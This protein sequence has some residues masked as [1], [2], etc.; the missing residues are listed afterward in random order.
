MR[1]LIDTN[2][3]LDLLVRRQ[4]WEREA[5]LIRGMAYFGDAELWVPAKSFT[6]LFYIM[7][8][9]FPS[10]CVQQLF[11]ECRKDFHLCSL[12]EEDV[13]EACHRSWSDFEDCLVSVC[14]EKVKAD[15]IITRDASGFLKSKVAVLTP[16]EFLERMEQE[17]DLYYELISLF[18]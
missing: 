15:W 11:L 12:N 13:F 8:K 10:D 16:K 9:E 1:L 4:P 7:T 14:A 5:L 17:Y 2:V 6:D 18:E 3:M